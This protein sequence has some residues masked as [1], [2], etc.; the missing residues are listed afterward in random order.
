MLWPFAL[1][2]VV[3]VHNMFNFDVDGQSPYTKF[4]G[5]HTL[6]ERV[7]FHP[8]GCPVFVLEAKLQTSSKSLPKWEPLSRLGIFLGHSPIHAG[9]AALVLNPATG[10]VSPQYHLVFDNAST[11]VSHM[12]NGTVLENWKHLVE[13]SSFGS[14]DREYNLDDTWFRES[15]VDDDDPDSASP[16]LGGASEDDLCG[17]ASLPSMLS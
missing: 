1:Q 8:F 10:H 5:A 11:T 16:L 4:T 12:R 9:S 17:S 13:N 2:Y 7:D 15:T 14:I 6:P 3:K